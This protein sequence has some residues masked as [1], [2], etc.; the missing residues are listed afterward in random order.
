M[1]CLAGGGCGMPGSDNVITAK[2]R[3]QD[4][5]VLTVEWSGERGGGGERE[6]LGRVREVD[7]IKSGEG[8]ELFVAGRHRKKKNPDPEHM[9]SRITCPGTRL[10]H[11]GWT[12]PR[13]NNRRTSIRSAKTHWHMN[14]TTCWSQTEVRGGTMRRSPP[15]TQLGWLTCGQVTEGRPQR[16]WLIC[17]TAARNLACKGLWR[18][19]DVE[20]RQ[21]RNVVRLQSVTQ[22]LMANC[23]ENHAD[24]FIMVFSFLC[25][26]W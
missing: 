21:R 7:W 15:D 26:S 16:S 8:E 18:R 9:R 23:W 12:R 22:H 13:Q 14:T 5:A 10:K 11:S 6:A 20:R 25:W 1:D 24:G 17:H 19:G 2:K 3:E 4:Q